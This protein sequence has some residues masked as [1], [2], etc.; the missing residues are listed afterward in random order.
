MHQDCP[1]EGD[2]E[3]LGTASQ[4]DAHAPPPLRVLLQSRLALLRQPT[5]LCSSTP[6]VHQP[7]PHRAPVTRVSRTGRKRTSP[8]LAGSPP[9]LPAPVTQ[10]R[11]QVRTR[12]ARAHTQFV[13][14]ANSKY[15]CLEEAT[16][17]LHDPGAYSLGCHLPCPRPAFRQLQIKS[18]YLVDLFCPNPAGEA[19]QQGIGRGSRS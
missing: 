7:P 19:T 2:V 3:A 14:S 10:D 15:R 13:Q 6:R 16:P 9:N 5:A 4:L 17:A 11:T 1:R 12:R 18:A 8:R